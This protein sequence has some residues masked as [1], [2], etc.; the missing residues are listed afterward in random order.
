MATKLGLY[1][2]NLSETYLMEGIGVSSNVYLIDRE[3]LY[4]VDAGAGDEANQLVPKIKALNLDPENIEQIILTHGHFDHTGGIEE[5]A[6]FASPKILIHGSDSE[7]LETYGLELIKLD[8]NALL[9]VGSH[10]LQ[11]I[12]TSGHTSGSMC[13]YDSTNKILF[14]GD[15]V[16]PGG[17]FGR[18]DLGGN[19]DELLK[20]LELLTHLEVDFLLPGHMKPVTRNA[21]LQ[22]QAS[23]QNALAWI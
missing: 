17:S 4:L 23:Y 5:I 20:S 22:I 9:E 2:Q 18:T 12:H 7:D 1:D 19:D 8:D 13:L 16:F 15:T 21:K 3:R 14:S 6:R 11:V 10:R